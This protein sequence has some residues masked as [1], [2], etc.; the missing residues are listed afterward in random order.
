MFH[1]IQVEFQLDGELLCCFHHL[2]TKSRARRSVFS[3]ATFLE[4]NY[5]LF[6]NI[7][8]HSLYNRLRRIKGRL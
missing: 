5:F 6:G 1:K 4:K 3:S 8:A 7:F 2:S